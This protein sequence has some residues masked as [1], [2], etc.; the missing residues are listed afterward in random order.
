M[1][2]LFPTVLLLAACFAEL[3]PQAQLLITSPEFKQLDLDYNL[4]KIAWARM[5]ND[6]HQV[7]V[8]NN[9][10]TRA[11]KQVCRVTP[12]QGCETWTAL[13]EDDCS[14]LP[15]RAN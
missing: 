2:A 13:V 4:N 14:K 11:V 12:Y 15:T 6:A 8:L 9:E 5:D 1:R 7:C 3:P 10:L